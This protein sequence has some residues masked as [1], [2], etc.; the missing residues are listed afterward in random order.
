MNHHPNPET[1]V[2]DGET[3][4]ATCPYC[5]RPFRRERFQVLHVAEV[6][7]D[8]AT[9]TER[10]SYEA[11]LDEESDDLFVYHLKVLFALGALY[12]A[13]IISSIVA[14]SIAG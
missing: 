13:F 14:F 3:P 11:V 10:E 2:P 5:E 7:P 12:A 4:E 8:R 9:A 1:A 6:H